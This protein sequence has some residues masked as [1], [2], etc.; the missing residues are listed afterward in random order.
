MSWCPVGVREMGIACSPLCPVGS[1]LRSSPRLCI[2]PHASPQYIPL[3]ITPS[4][5]NPGAITPLQ[6]H[7][8]TQCLLAIVQIPWCPGCRSRICVRGGA[9]RVVVVANI[10]ASKLGIKGRGAQAPRGPSP[11]DPPLG[12][13]I[14]ALLHSNCISIARDSG[15]V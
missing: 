13:P 15:F 14:V 9:K 10:W 5:Q 12:Y 4:S 6:H 1:D 11:L 2:T 3:T 8:I 7:Q